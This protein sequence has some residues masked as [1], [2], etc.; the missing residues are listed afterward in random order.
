MVRTLTP[1]PLTNGTRVALIALCALFVASMRMPPLYF[2]NQNTKFLHGMATAFP[3][4]LGWDWTAST[5]DGLPVFTAVVH[6][7]ARWADPAMFY[8][9][10][11]ALL[12]VMFLSLVTLARWMAPRHGASLA[13][14]VLVGSL[15]VVLVHPPNE[16]SLEG[17]ALQYLT[18]G[19]FQPAE[20]GIL[21]LPAVLL[22][23]RRHPAALV[24]AALPAV[25]H[26]TYIT[27]SAITLAVFLVDRRRAGLRTSPLLLGLCAAMLVL[28]PLDLALRFAPTDAAIFEQANAFLAFHRI[29]HHSD[30]LQWADERA[31]RKLLLA[32][33]AI[34]LAP[35]GVLRWL[36]VA[37]V[38]VAVA[39]AAFVALTGNAEVALMAPWRTSVVVVPLSM[40]IVIGRLGDWLF[41][42]G[43]Q[44]WLGAALAAPMLGWAVLVASDGAAV[45]WQQLTDPGVPDHIEFIRANRA[46]GDIYLTTPTMSD[47]RLQAMVPQY[48]TWKTHPYLD[49]EVIEWNRRAGLAVS[50]FHPAAVEIGFD[51][52]S[53][54]RLLDTEQVTHVLVPIGAVEAA[55]SCGPLAE[56]YEGGDFVVFEVAEA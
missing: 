43:G 35:A 37:F 4:Q 23:L 17:V 9:I 40:A 20:F 14:V 27:F 46:P 16:D 26:P 55:R 48:V 51:C 11:V 45:K 34:V 5:V 30:P 32:L 3:E 49:T 13:F 47:F 2:N 6:L 56:R 29:P 12:S 7:V 41:A 21:F 42:R 8:V 25:F 15:L 1:S 54:E 36:L 18:R 19:Y 53:L 10:E 38:A 52:A 22:A 44:P 50:V 28:P 39:G 33:V 24:L 31:L